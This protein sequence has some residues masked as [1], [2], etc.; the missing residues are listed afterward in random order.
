MKEMH[1]KII[2]GYHLIREEGCCQKRQEI[3]NVG[4]DV[5]ERKRLDTVSENVKWYCHYGK[6]FGSSSKY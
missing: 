5:E 3:T 1:L 2:I 4:K 6:Q